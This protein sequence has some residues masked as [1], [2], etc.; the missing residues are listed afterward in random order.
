MTL[1]A[2][3]ETEPAAAVAASARTR[4]AHI[5]HPARPYLSSGISAGQPDLE[6]GLA[7]S[8][9]S[10]D[11]GVAGARPAESEGGPVRA[12]RRHAGHRS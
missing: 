4:R 2:E 11:T 9:R 8:L 6:E 1:H 5:P 3:I 10:A 7:Q 12:R